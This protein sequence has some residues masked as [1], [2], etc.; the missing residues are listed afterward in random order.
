MGAVVPAET[1]WA[2]M[3][4]TREIFLIHGLPLSLYSD[5][6]SI[7]HTLR[8]PTTIEQLKNI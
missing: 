5:R 4:L 2:Y 8:E 6:H 3:N 1:T 7:F